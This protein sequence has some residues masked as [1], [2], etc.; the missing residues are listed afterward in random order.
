MLDSC[1]QNDGFTRC[2]MPI[3]LGKPDAQAQPLAPQGGVIDFPH[4]FGQ[5]V[6][7]HRAVVCPGELFAGQQIFV[8]RINDGMQCIARQPELFM[9][10]ELIEQ[11]KL[12]LVHVAVGNDGQG[13]DSR[14]GLGTVLDIFTLF[15][16]LFKSS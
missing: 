2:N 10:S 1:N 4:Q 6:L 12:R 8:K 9:H 7:V 5:R 15:I 16:F 11:C 13:N 3:N 14:G